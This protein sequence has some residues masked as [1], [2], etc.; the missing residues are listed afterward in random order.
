MFLGK[1]GHGFPWLSFASAFGVRSAPPRFPFFFYYYLSFSF[2]REIR[3]GGALFYFSFSH[4]PAI[5]LLLISDMICDSGRL[6]THKHS[7]N[8]LTAHHGLYCSIVL[9]S[10]CFIFYFSFDP[11]PSTSTVQTRH[12]WTISMKHKLSFP[13]NPFEQPKTAHPTRTPPRIP[14]GCAHDSAPNSLLN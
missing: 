14:L 5:R 11:S 1:C 13:K 8:G 9:K 6:T 4:S 10:T 2:D 7:N 12:R 3:V